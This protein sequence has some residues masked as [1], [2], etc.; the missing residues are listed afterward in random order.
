MN[1]PPVPPPPPQAQQQ[2]DGQNDN[3]DQIFQE[4][5]GTLL[6]AIEELRQQIR[7]ATTATKAATAAQILQWRHGME[8]IM[9]QIHH[10]LG[11]ATTELQSDLITNCEQ[12][13]SQV[14]L[15]ALQSSTSRIEIDPLEADPELERQ[16]QGAIARLAE[17]N[18]SLIRCSSS[19]REG[20]GNQQDTTDEIVDLYVQYQRDVI[21]Q[22]SKP[23][24]ARLV[25][26][27]NH[28]RKEED[29]EERQKSQH[30]FVVTTILGQASALIHPLMMW[31]SN[32]PPE[33]SD[34]HELCTKSVSVLDEQAQTLS[35][36]VITWCIEDLKVDD[37][38]AAS[39]DNKNEDATLLGQLDGVVEEVAFMCQVLDRYISLMNGF[40]SHDT[41]TPVIQQL[42]P[43]LTWKYASLERYLTTKQWKSA[44][45][46]ANPVQIVMGTQIQVPSV[47]EDAQYLST[48]SLKRA[49][50]T[51]NAKA[52]GTVAHSIATD[53]WSTDNDI[54]EGVHQ[55]LLDQKGCWKDQQAE[56]NKRSA[57]ASNGV[58]SPKNPSSS[59][60]ASA[61]MDALDDDLT[62]SKSVATVATTG[63]L[64]KP[65]QQ[66]APGSAGILGSLSSLTGGGGGSDIFLRIRLDTYFCALNGIYSA[67]AACTSLVNFLD[68]LHDNEDRDQSPSTEAI[69]DDAVQP[70]SSPSSFTDAMTQL[71]RE[72]LF[73]YSNDYG[74][75]LEVQVARVVEEFCGTPLD[76]SA[77]K[78]PRFLPIIKYYLEREEYQLAN[79]KE[80]QSREDDIR[81]HQQWIQP[82]SESIFLS[83]LVGN[84][85]VN[86]VNVIHERLASV[87]VELVLN[88]V[89][90][91]KFTDWGS[92]LLSKQIRL[93]QQHLAQHLMTSS[94][95][96][97]AT[98]PS[99]P[100]EKLSQ[101]LTVLQLEKPSDWSMYYQSTSILSI[102]ELE[103]FLKLRVDFSSEA[104]AAVITS[105]CKADEGS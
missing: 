32:L 44:L 102:E 95:E 14:A 43:E 73:R 38:I 9:H 62:T 70:P 31:K 46:L 29:E 72:E 21:R 8:G 100:W 45:A 34:L 5:I 3:D 6:M 80:L 20:G 85:E 65:K 101:V 103:Q 11:Q 93:V 69:T 75:L 36:R 61:L 10:Q 97:P 60:F 86:V 68:S 63:T 18:L 98:M 48:R 16:C 19:R 52:I 33:F 59:T 56:V 58:T 99:Q 41:T 104:V 53:I 79:S 13:A 84:C 89:V 64:S 35:Q 4:R 96:L 15:L 51:L 47:V 22:R 67:S 28:D 82:L 92:L 81:L 94:G 37:W 105:I 90:A 1:P 54:L 49:A 24:I 88:G 42:H 74:R 2:E 83:E 39:S 66:N 7:G 55:A 17:L 25:N 23:S 87:F 77:Y 91:K 50:S 26:Y 40:G 71:A 27:R 12:R 78:S 30:S 57:G 76:P